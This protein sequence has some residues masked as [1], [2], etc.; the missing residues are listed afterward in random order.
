MVKQLAGL[1]VRI[2]NI[3]MKNPV[4]LASGTYEY[5]E[6]TKGLID[7]KKLGAIVTKT[8][9]LEP[10]K[11]NTPPRT[12]ETYGGM[13]NAI[14]LQNKGV[15][16]FLRNILPE[17]K[18]L[19]I[20]VIASIAGADK[21]EFKDLARIL[22]K[23]SEVA[24]LEL[25]LSCPNIQAKKLFSQDAVSTMDIV[26]SVKEVTKKT[27]IAKLSPNVTDIK[28]IAKAAQEAKADAIALVNTFLALAIDI[29]KRK[30]ILGNTTGGLSGPA[31]KPVALRMVWEAAN[32][33]KIPIIG[34]GGIF[35]AEDAI[36]FIIA[37]A[38]AVAIGTGS[39]I[40]P[41]LGTETIEGVKKYLLKHKI[42][43]IKQLTGC[44]N[45]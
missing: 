5:N 29:E 26:A 2:G 13:L 21:K 18:N 39:F 23:R 6:T 24:G 37:G 15:E 42:K 31:I 43:D 38:T 8:I 12:C 45:K 44:M 35:S 17:L 20:P 9:T 27:V 25:N 33:V 4:M 7:I 16:D 34:M 14:G 36:S 30:P 22:D 41:A 28:H 11:G 1:S 32:A 10:R 3:K 40:N 19:N